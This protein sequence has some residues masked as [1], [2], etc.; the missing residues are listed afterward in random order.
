MVRRN[1]D[2]KLGSIQMRNKS[3]E[4]AV[5]P[6]MK[7]TIPSWMESSSRAVEYCSEMEMK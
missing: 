7:F 3:E 5:K 6:G 1:V 4:R 2:R